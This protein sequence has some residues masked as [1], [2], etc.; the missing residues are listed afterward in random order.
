[1][2]KKIIKITITGI[3]F[4]TLG[5]LFAQNVNIEKKEELAR[6]AIIPFEDNTG[7]KNYSYMPKSLVK[8]I[9][10]SMAQNFR[11]E[12]IHPE[13][14]IPALQKMQVEKKEKETQNDIIKKVAKELRADIVIFG[15]YTVDQ[16]TQKIVI[17]VNLFLGL[18]NE[19]VKIPDTENAIDN[20]IFTA[21]E[22]VASTLVSEIDRMVADYE[23]KQKIASTES[24]GGKKSLT[25]DFAGSRL[26]WKNKKFD[27]TANGSWILFPGETQDSPHNLNLR[28]RFW[29]T[30]GLYLGL[31]GNAFFMFNSPLSLSEAEFSGVS[32]AGFIGYGLALKR[33]QLYA[34][35]GGGYYMG[36]LR[37]RNNSI[38]TTSNQTSPIEEVVAVQNPMGVVQ[39]GAEYLIFSFVS[40]GVYAEGKLF[41]DDPNS[42]IAVSAGVTAGLV[43]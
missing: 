40:L 35:L 20:T 9:D 7:T 32:V 2:L 29:P 16:E 19:M 34:D 10:G 39:L 5:T 21:T 30:K 26:D 23:K 13:E 11:Y 41:Y 28:L 37:I 42:I 8:A 22:K 43:F 3:F 4:S 18:T 33:F 6:V 36:E 1:M 15:G 38:Q 14:V 17:S 12:K 25:R 24:E 31:E 27:L